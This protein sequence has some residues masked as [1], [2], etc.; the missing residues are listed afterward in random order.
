[1][2]RS[3]LCALAAVALCACGGDD[4]TGPTGSI[5]VGGTWNVSLTN[6]SG[7]GASCSSTEP[8]RLTIRQ[9]ASTFTG[10]YSGGILNCLTPTESFSTAVG[11]GTVINGEV[12]GNNV[13][14]DL[15]SPQFH[16]EGTVTGS[17]M[18]GTAEWTY[19]FGLPL[20]EVNLTG[21]WSAIR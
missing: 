3:W 10:T 5:N 4:T 1:M 7:G 6:L 15:D 17:S 13:S 18:A 20:G 16:Q 9:T 12:S 14:F 8:T 2:P 11:S 19:D 21:G